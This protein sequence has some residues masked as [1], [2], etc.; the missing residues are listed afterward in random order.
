[1]EVLGELLKRRAKQQ[2]LRAE[3][4]RNKVLTDIKGIFLDALD[5]NI[6]E[7]QQIMDQLVELVHKY[8]VDTEGQ[9]KL[10]LKAERKFENKVLEKISKKIAINQVELTNLITVLERILAKIVKLFGKLSDVPNL[11]QDVKNKLQKIGED[12]KGSVA[13][14]ALNPS[15]SSSHLV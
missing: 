1:M 14:L 6:D 7:S 4:K 15:T 9:E 12:F 13:Q 10:L 11:T 5:I 2:K 8:Q 3:N